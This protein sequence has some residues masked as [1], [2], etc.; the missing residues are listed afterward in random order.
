MQNENL[1]PVDVCKTHYKVE[2]SFLQILNEHGF[3]HLVSA[4][5]RQFI[6]TEELQTLEKFIRLHYD[7]DI[8][9]EGIEA[10]NF[11]LERVQNMQDEIAYLRSKLTIYEKK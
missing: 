8:N 6:D 10:I 4:E 9:M 3:I 1:I 5:E 2:L 7:L 11:L